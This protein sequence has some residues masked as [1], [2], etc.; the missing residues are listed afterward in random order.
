MPSE[1]QHLLS[2]FWGGAD[3]QTSEQALVAAGPDHFLL[4]LIAKPTPDEPKRAIDNKAV[5]SPG[6]AV[7][8]GLILSANPGTGIPLHMKVPCRVCAVVIH[9]HFIVVTLTRPWPF[10]LSTLSPQVD[11]KLGAHVS[12]ISALHAVDSSGLLV[13]QLEKWKG[14]PAPAQL[15]LDARAMLLKVT[16]SPRLSKWYNGT[17]NLCTR[18]TR[19]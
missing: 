6:V 5:V 3:Q 19:L 9:V 16:S 18:I 17:S 7:P 15:K 2:Y 10:I 11:V 4:R 13:K 12:L 14:L 1:D 8:E